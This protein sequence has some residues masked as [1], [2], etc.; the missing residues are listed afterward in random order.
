MVKKFRNHN[1]AFAQWD[2]II[3][4]CR[5]LDR[6]F[7]AAMCVD[8][9]CSY[10]EYEISKPEGVEFKS[11]PVFCNQHIGELEVLV[12]VACYCQVKR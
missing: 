10:K 1:N 6:H 2:N 11:M 12:P 4:K 3:V 9:D 7:V 8:S 5:K